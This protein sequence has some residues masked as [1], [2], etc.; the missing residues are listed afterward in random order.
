M[1][2]QT[3][4]KGLITF[5]HINVIINSHQFLWMLQFYFYCTTGTIH[6]KNF[7]FKKIIEFNYRKM[8]QLK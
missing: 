3:N 4:P 1:K 8:F 2:Y 7:Y 5:N 6:I